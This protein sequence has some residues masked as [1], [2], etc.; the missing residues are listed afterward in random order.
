MDIAG[1]TVTAPTRPSNS[2]LPNRLYCASLR[3][4]GFSRRFWIGLIAVAL[5][6]GAWVHHNVVQSYCADGHCAD[7]GSPEYL[8]GLDQTNTDA[9]WLA[10]IAVLLVVILGFALGTALK[11]VR[12]LLAR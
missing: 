5:L 6:G 3:S 8:A 11:L 12:R 1:A 4:M 9:A 7:Q 2:R 10:L